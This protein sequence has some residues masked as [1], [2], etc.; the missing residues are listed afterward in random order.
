MRSFKV[1]FLRPLDDVGEVGWA[2]G[3]SLDVGGVSLMLGEW[4]VTV[5]TDEVSEM[6]LTG[7]ALAFSFKED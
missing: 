1:C 6:R 5:V 4:T 2:R 7:R 3:V